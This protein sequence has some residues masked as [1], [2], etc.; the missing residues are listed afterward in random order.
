MD[1]GADQIPVAEDLYETLGVGRDAS[2]DAIQK[3]YRKLARKYHPDMNPE[4]DAAKATFKRVQEAY[5]VL[6]DADKRAAYDRYGADFE[7]I[8]SGGWHPGAAAE[9]SFDGLDLEQIFGGG[10]RGARGGVQFEGGF[11][12][13]FDQLMG[14][15]GAAGRRA[16]PGR[17][18]GAA[19]RRGSNVRHE[20]EIPLATAVLGGK[21]EFYLDRG[22]QREKLS[23]S[24]PPGVETGSKIRLRDQGHLSPNG[25]PRGDLILIIKVSDHPHFRRNGRSL[26]LRLPVTIAEAVLGARVDVPTPS[27]TVTLTI[28]AGSSG[29]KRLRLRGQGVRSR[30]GS[31]GDLIVE[32]QIAVPP[33]IDEESKKLI[34]EF[35]Q[36]NPAKLRTNLGF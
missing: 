29:G 11:A 15:G 36:R 10:S 18:P 35:D 3:A 4:N 14:A 13:F 6:S 26:E 32:L 30:D 20:L 12:D 31:A 2:K 9:T 5:D 8:R 19:P 27:G 17:R 23:V 16:G 33:T 24:I 34:E 7:K 28:P 25:G 1:M 22:G 21:T